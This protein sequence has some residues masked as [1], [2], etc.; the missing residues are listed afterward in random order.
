M[1]T[2]SG[3]IEYH[4]VSSVVAEQRG[5]HVAE[6]IVAVSWA[7]GEAREVSVVIWDLNDIVCEL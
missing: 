6:V 7:H 5:Y 3:H 1:T 2:P 4:R